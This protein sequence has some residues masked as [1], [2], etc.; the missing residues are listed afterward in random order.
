MGFGRSFLLFLSPYLHQQVHIRELGYL[1]TISDSY[2]RH[3]V[4][5]EKALYG[6]T[7]SIEKK[8]HGQRKSDD[9]EPYG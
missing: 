4:Q 5:V 8:L 3:C 7:Q 2:D 1:V 6:Q 9:K